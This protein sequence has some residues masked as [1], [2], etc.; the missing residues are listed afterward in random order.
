MSQIKITRVTR[1]PLVF[2]EQYWVVHVDEKWFY[3]IKEGA[4]YILAIESMMRDTA[5][6]SH[7]MTPAGMTPLKT[8]STVL[9]QNAPRVLSF[10]IN[11]VVF[12]SL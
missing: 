6:N 12:F 8:T 1:G 3:L 4:K 9:L 7:A 5:N 2:D 10:G 11:M